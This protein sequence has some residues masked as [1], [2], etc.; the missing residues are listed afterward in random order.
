[1]V[2]YLNVRAENIKLLEENMGRILCHN[3]YHCVCVCVCVC[4]LSPK[5][6]KTKAEIKKWD[7]IQLKSFCTA[8]ESNDKTKI[9][10]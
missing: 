7:L 1:M 4:D 8:K 6:E 9:I 3:P 5:A 2:K 10:Y